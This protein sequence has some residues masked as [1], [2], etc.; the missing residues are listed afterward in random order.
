MQLCISRY[1]V[2]TSVHPS[3]CLSV[4]FVL[5][6]NDRDHLETANI[7]MN[8][9][10]HSIVLSHVA[11][12]M[13][14]TSHNNEGLLKVTASHVHYMTGCDFEKSFVFKKTVEITSHVRFPIHVQTYIV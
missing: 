12:R 1:A 2:V 6:R 4:T 10:R 7:G 8:S 3:V 9:A 13:N 14:G 11:Y 5:Y